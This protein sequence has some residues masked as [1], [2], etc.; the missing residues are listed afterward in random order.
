M[1][2]TGEGRLD[3]TSFAGKVVGGVVRDASAL[4]VD[5][6]VIAGRVAE[7]VE[8]QV[9]DRHVHVVSLV[10]GFGELRAVEE[11]LSC[12]EIVVRESLDRFGEDSGPR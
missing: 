12:I 7:G 3:R 8:A 6:L 10:Q 11:T 5:V 4:G 2:V 1:V 9:D